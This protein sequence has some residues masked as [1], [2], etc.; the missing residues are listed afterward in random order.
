MTK[1]R[2]RSRSPRKKVSMDCFVDDSK[3]VALHFNSE[4]DFDRAVTLLLQ[5]RATLQAVGFD[6]LLIDKEALEKI[7]KILKH[8]AVKF[9]DVPIVAMSDLSESERKVL[10]HEQ[11]S[12]PSFRELMREPVE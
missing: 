6:V 5:A 9:E 7:Q 11:K 12:R 1:K 4:K 10:R 8:E 2:K 3:W